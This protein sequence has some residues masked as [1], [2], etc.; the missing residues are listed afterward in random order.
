[1]TGK[2]CMTR[3]QELAPQFKG[4]WLAVGVGVV[5]YLLVAPVRVFSGHRP[6]RMAP[7]G[8]EV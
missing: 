2:A 3:V 1:M 6:R 7:E 4:L 8:R 5:F